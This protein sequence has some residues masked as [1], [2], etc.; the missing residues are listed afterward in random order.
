VDPQ[1]RGPDWMPITPKAGSLFHADSHAVFET[2]SAADLYL[3][4]MEDGGISG[5]NVQK[6]RRD[7]EKE[8]S[9]GSDP[10][11]QGLNGRPGP[12]FTCG[13]FL[14][15]MSR[16]WCGIRTTGSSDRLCR[17]KCGQARRS[18]HIGSDERGSHV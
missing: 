2:A 16:K 7:N 10:P 18:R 6:I 1:P 5:Q 9:L 17:H 15:K 14:D 12:T 13:E 3:E 8:S 11:L 4:R